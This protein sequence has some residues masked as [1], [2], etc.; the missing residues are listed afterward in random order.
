MCWKSFLRTCYIFKTGTG[1]HLHQVS[2]RCIPMYSNSFLNV[3]Q[4]VAVTC[5][6]VIAQM[7]SQEM[8]HPL[9][10]LGIHAWS[11]G[12]MLGLKNKRSLPFIFIVRKQPVF[13]HLNLQSETMS[14]Q[15]Q[16]CHGRISSVLKA[17]LLVGLLKLV[18]AEERM[19]FPSVL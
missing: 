18:S 6:N 11:L 5:T 7:G 2:M 13:S 12:I 19:L 3:K 15:K 16:H 14:K 10:P 1:N 8:M 9:L 17:A 4:W